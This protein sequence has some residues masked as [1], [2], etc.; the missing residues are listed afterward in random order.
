MTTS[1]T[2]SSDVGPDTQKLLSYREMQERLY[3]SRTQT[4]RLERAGARLLPDVMIAP[5]TSG[6]KPERVLQ[7]GIDT[8]RLAEDGQPIGGWD[9]DRPINRVPDGSLPAMRRLVEEKY[10]SPPRVYLGSAHCSYLYGLQELA[11]YFL[12][13]RGAFIPA[14]VQVGT[15]FF[16]WDEEEVIRFGRQTGR[17]HDPATLR[18]WAVRRTEEFG[19]DPR[20]PWVV[21]LLGEDNLPELAVNDTPD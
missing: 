16:G 2:M 10:S 7:Y 15:K 18:A 4:F 1:G 8:H 14:A 19:L 3:L 12:R 17:L 13:K 21:D 20:T 5:G 9:G 6:W 11:V